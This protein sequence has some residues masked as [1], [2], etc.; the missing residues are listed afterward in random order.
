MT[1]TPGDEA[2]FEAANTS[3]ITG[4]MPTDVVSL[5]KGVF[6]KFD[7]YDS[8]YPQVETQKYVFQ[9]AKADMSAPRV[10]EVFHFFHRDYRMAYMVMEYIDFTPAPVPDLPERVALA[11]QWPRDLPVPLDGVLMGPLG[12]GRARHTLF[13]NHR[14]SLSFSSIEAIKRYLL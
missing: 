5:S 11:V 14:A 7:C 8:L 10:P 3:V 1:V 6:V 12:G 9:C 2:A 13:K 4:S